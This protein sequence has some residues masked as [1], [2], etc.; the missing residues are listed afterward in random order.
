MVRGYG[1]LP[2][3]DLKCSGSL[4]HERVSHIWLCAI[5]QR[6]NEEKYGQS[7]LSVSQRFYGRA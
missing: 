6:R 5:M 2:E 3:Y 1:R 7:D 4:R